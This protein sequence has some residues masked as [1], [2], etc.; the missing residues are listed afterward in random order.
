MVLGRG[1]LQRWREGTLE[2]TGGGDGIE[3]ASDGGKGKGMVIEQIWG[4]WQL[5]CW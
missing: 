2:E 3:L 5:E 1:V 4:G